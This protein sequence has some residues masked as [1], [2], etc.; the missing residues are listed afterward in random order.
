MQGGL[1]RYQLPIAVGALLALAALALLAGLPASWVLLGVCA[2]ATIPVAVWGLVTLRIFEPLPFLMGACAVLFVIRPLQLLVEAGELD[3]YVSSGDP[4]RRLVLLEGQELA[5]FVVE[6]VDE[7]LDAALARGL[8]ACAVFLVL[9]LAGYLLGP[10]RALARRLARLATRSRPAA[11]PRAL[12]IALALGLAAQAI[13]VARV[14]GPAASLRSAADQEALRQSFV[15]FVMA[16]FAPAAL[17][18]WTAW[19][20][21]RRAREWLAFLAALAAVCGFFVMTGSRERLLILA[22]LLAV[23]VHYL[24]RPWRRRE[25]VGFAVLLVCLVSSL[26]VF[27]GLANTYSLGEAAERA[28]EHLVDGRVILNDLTSFD[29]VLYATSTYG[30][31]LDHERGAFLLGGV[32]SFVPGA[33]DPG[34]PEGGDIVFRKAIWGSELRTGRP[35]TA[36][37]DLFIDFGFAGVAVGALLIGILARALLGLLRGPPAGREYRVALYALLLVILVEAMQNT[38][39][40]ALGYS[41]T[42]LLPFLVTVHVLAGRAR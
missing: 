22:I 13:I 8:G 5:R 2:A 28:P 39:S 31:S 27:R 14:G 9:L 38:F 40:I 7:P 10:G 30:R 6:R 20:R 12:A 33:I 42:L 34:K 37:G 29:H 23:P 17:V 24:W 21:P 32:R 4:I 36:V 35:P 19:Q 11:V 26:V 1:A 25:L 18:V 15:L 3:T 41:I 16:G